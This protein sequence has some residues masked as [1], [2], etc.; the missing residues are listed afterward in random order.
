M[1]HYKT[2]AKRIFDKCLYLRT[3]VCLLEGF[4]LKGKLQYRKE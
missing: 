3:V 2:Y 4:H 1:R